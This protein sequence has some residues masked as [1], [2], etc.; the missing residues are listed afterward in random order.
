MKRDEFVKL[1]I[2][3]PKRAARVLNKKAK[4]LSGCRKVTKTADVLSDILFVTER[5][6]FSDCKK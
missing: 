3:D 2:N 4:E 1:A 6:I 5:T